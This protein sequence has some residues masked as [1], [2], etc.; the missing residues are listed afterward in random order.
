LN[1]ELTWQEPRK[2][3][4][5]E[6]LSSLLEAIQMGIANYLL[7]PLEWGKIDAALQRCVENV[8]KA[9]VCESL[10]SCS[11]TIGLPLGGECLRG[12][13]GR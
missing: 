2:L 4:Q 11:K 7:K 1:D 12:K 6:S 10:V 9:R 3:H 13:V 5:I 8:L